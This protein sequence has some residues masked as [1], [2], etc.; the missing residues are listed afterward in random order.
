MRDHVFN[1]TDASL[2]EVF[3]ELV[4]NSMV[5]NLHDWRSLGPLSV[6]ALAPLS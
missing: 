5:N 4:G 1:V 6:L 3:E 2:V